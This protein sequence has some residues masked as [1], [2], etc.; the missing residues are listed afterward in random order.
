M[1]E[2]TRVKEKMPPNFVRVLTYSPG[3]HGAVKDT[4]KGLTILLWNEEEKRWCTD[5]GETAMF[6]PT[7]WAELPRVG[8]HVSAEGVADLWPGGG[9][10]WSR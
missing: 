7:H 3:Y 1:F 8:L 10:A 2:M 4:S 5:D 6:T 9:R